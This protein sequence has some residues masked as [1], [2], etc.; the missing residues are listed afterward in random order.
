MPPRGQLYLNWFVFLI[1]WPY[2]VNK[3]D[4]FSFPE[5]IFSPIFYWNF[6]VD[7]IDWERSVLVTSCNSV[8]KPYTRDKT[9]RTLA[10]RT[11]DFV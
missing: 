3:S 5:K 8:F 6:V 1:F 2:F 4:V 9:S 10:T 11:S 7:G